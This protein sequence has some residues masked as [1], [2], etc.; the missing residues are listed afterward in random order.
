MA[1]RACSVCAKNEGVSQSLGDYA[2][3]KAHYNHNNAE[4]KEKNGKLRKKGKTQKR[5]ASIR[6]G[7]ERER[8]RVCAMYVSRCM[9][10]TIGSLVHRLTRFPMAIP[11][12]SSLL[13]G[14]NAAE[15]TNVFAIPLDNLSPHHLG[16]GNLNGNKQK[17]KR[18]RGREQKIKNGKPPFS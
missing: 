7:V 4:F 12:Q 10:E 16:H 15:E 13:I 9:S 6:Q 8:E 14:G 5:G 18:E 11:H 2:G 3:H 1:Y 17:Q